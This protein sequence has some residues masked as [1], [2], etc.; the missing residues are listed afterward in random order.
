MIKSVVKI[1]FA[2]ISLSG[3]VS[4]AD[5]TTNDAIPERERAIIKALTERIPKTC[6]IVQ[7]TI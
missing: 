4:V 2:S 3:C 1:F 5:L 7:V 6:E